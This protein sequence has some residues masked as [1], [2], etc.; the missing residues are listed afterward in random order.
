MREEA[1]RTGCVMKEE[2]KGWKDG[3]NKGM[4]REREKREV[5]RYRECEKN[6][7]WEVKRKRRE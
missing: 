5:R 3:K 7:R 2:R 6:E 1:D 4:L